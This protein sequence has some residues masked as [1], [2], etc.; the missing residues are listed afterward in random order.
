MNGLNPHLSLQAVIHELDEENQNADKAE[1]GEVA[2]A[3]SNGEKCD[4]EASSLN[5]AVS[6]GRTVVATRYRSCLFQEPPSLYLNVDGV[7]KGVLYFASEPLDRTDAWELLHKDEMLIVTIDAG[8]TRECLSQ[9]CDAEVNAAAGAG[10]DQEELYG[11][12]EL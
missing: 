12:K 7:E 2:A 8:I 1:I 4:H 10:T 6:D 9:T 11:A 3:N 5:L